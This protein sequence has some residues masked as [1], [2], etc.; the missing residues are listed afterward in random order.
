V[1]NLQEFN[2]S[3]FRGSAMGQFDPMLK[4]TCRTF[5]ERQ[6]ELPV[7]RAAISVGLSFMRI[8]GLESS[9][10][11]YEVYEDDRGKASYA[12]HVPGRHLPPS[13]G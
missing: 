13:R 2:Y 12:W 1:R 3:F 6:S 4:V 11:W 7:N 9:S 10:H 5:S 8:M